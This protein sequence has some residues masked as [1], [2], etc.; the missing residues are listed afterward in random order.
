MAQISAVF[1]I[2]TGRRGRHQ[3]HKNFCDGA[4][5]QREETK[6]AVARIFLFRSGQ[7]TICDGPQRADCDQCARRSSCGK[8]SPDSAGVIA[9]GYGDAPGASDPEYSQAAGYSLST[10][11]TTTLYGI[12]CTDLHASRVLG[13]AINSVARPDWICGLENS[14]S[15]D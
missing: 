7:R 12:L 15:E 4:F 5:A 2:Q 8:R 14:K 6:P 1:Q 9:P 13:R 10:H 11:G 3:R